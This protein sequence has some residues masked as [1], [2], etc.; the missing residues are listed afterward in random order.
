MEEGVVSGAWARTMLVL[1]VGVLMAAGVVNVL[2][3]VTESVLWPVFVGV[4]WVVVA[5]GV[6]VWA[7]AAATSKS[8]TLR[9]VPKSAVAAVSARQR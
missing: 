3:A 8:R 5:A 6:S 4:G 9:A 1:A 7:D 2:I